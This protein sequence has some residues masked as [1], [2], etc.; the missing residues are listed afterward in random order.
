M[1]CYRYLLVFSLLLFSG[2]GDSSR[3]KDLPAL[4]PC[5]VLVTQGGAPLDGAYVELVSQ[6][7]STYSPSST[8]DTSGNA[9]VSTYGYP[10]A[11]QGKYKIIVRKSIDDDIVYGTNEYGE[12]AVVSSN[13]YNVVQD[14][15]GDVKQTPHEIEVTTDK[16]G[17]Q[18]TIDVGEAIRV[19]HRGSE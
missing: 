7:S 18:V 5:T 9:V 14:L 4:F 8:T 19:R 16:K 2:C 10:G 13:R 12:K 17:S 3:P 11:P 1:N 6:E 15:Y